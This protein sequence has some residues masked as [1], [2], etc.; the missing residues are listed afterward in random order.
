MM[1][2]VLMTIMMHYGRPDT[3]VH[4]KTSKVPTISV[5]G[6]N[7]VENNDDDNDHINILLIMM[8]MMM[9]IAM[10]TMIIT[11]TIRVRYF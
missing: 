1:I 2:M 11:M 10:K 6:E 5:L 4:E 9:T 7:N 3:T 8:M